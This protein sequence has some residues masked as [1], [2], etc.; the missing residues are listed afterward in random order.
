MGFEYVSMLPTPAQIREEYPLTD[1]LIKIKSD[2]DKEIKSIFEGT[3]DKF[4]M[5]IGPC[6]A[7]RK[8]S[9]LDYAVRLSKL[10]KDV[11]DKILFVPRVYTGKPRT[12]GDG[13]KGMLHQPDQ[14]KTGNMYDGI[15]AIRKLHMDVIKE[16]KMST[17][18][19]MLYPD[20]VRY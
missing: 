5:I 1:D 17:A 14:E 18:D 4:L 3:S 7:D 20:N 11:K 16:S 15:I 6:S 12:M 2:M 9:V 19:E 8:D 13:Y 10:Q